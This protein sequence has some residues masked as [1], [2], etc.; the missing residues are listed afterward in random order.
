VRWARYSYCV[1]THVFMVHEVLDL[2]LNSKSPAR[3]SSC[4]N[5][6]RDGAIIGLEVPP[7]ECPPIIS[8]SRWSTNT[9]DKN[10]TGS[11]VYIFLRFLFIFSKSIPC[12]C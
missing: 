6:A 9:E 3:V 4:N 12:F 11:E 8:S 5:L 1:L 2:D 10:S 7:L